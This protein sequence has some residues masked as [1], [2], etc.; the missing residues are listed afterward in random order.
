[1]HLPLSARSIASAGAPLRRKLASTVRPTG[2]E[3][4]FAVDDVIVS[5][6]DCKG[7]I[8]YANDVFLR[9]ASLSEREAI[10]A[11]HSVIRHP[12]MP[13]AVFK[14]LWETIEK[15]DEI[16]AY[17]LNMASNGDHYWVFAHVTPT[18]ALDGGITGYHS[19]R[20]VPDRDALRVIEPLYAE[21]KAIEDRASDRARGLAQSF[22]HLVR[23]LGSKG[24]SYDEFVFSL[25]R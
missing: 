17:V 1:M 12:A 5:K 23:L 11:P 4:T 21:L 2:V 19:N 22:D 15:G 8:T 13:R 16:F 7:I 3:R 14:L 18:F 9:L 20:R 24:L 6:T 10:G 25:A